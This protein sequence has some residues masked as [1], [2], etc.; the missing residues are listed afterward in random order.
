MAIGVGLFLAAGI[1]GVANSCFDVGAL[2]GALGLRRAA[3]RRGRAR[4]DVTPPLFS[5]P[6]FLEICPLSLSLSPPGHHLTVRSATMA[7]RAGFHRSIPAALGA[8]FQ[9]SVR[10]S[11]CTVA[12]AL[13]YADCVSRETTDWVI[14]METGCAIIV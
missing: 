8:L 13:S 5:A 14:R 11:L 9:P 10:V 2:P 4:L 7:A 12:N 1:A 3:F 6:L